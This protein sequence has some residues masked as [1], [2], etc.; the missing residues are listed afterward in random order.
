MPNITLRPAT[1][2]DSLL[3]AR[4]LL[5]AMEIL[6]IDAPVP[7]DMLASLKN[8]E[9]STHDSKR[10]YS[11]E[12]C[13]VAEV[14]GEP[15]GCIVSYDG[16]DYA[17]LRKRTFDILYEECGLDLRDNPMETVPGEYYLDCMA[18]KG[19]FR[20]MG[21]GHILMNAAIE[22]GKGLGIR[23]FTLLVAKPHGNLESYYSE[24]G[25]KPKEEMFA[26]GEYYVKMEFVSE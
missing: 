6:D 9:A 10:L 22:K 23:R 17:A 14:D 21:I 8:L 3:I 4:C 5:A 7:P 18:I 26:F 1:Q 2:S 15:A 16:K 11:L 20:R 12:N 25:F 24:L 19:K 13:I